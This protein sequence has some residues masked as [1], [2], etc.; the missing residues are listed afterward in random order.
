MK[1]PD[2]CDCKLLNML[3]VPLA[4]YADVM[5]V[6]VGTLFP[7]KSMRLFVVNTGYVFA[8]TVPVR[9]ILVEFKV[10]LGFP[11]PIETTPTVLFGYKLRFPPLTVTVVFVFPK[12]TMPV[13][14]VAKLLEV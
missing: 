11:F 10:I 14:K 12:V 2:I 5:L 9:L 1:F 6:L 8:L 13:A 3:L 7:D 4:V